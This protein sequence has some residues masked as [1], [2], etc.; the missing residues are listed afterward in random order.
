MS[1][2]PG[3]GTP[4]ATDDP[5]SGSAAKRKPQHNSK[6]HTAFIKS[7]PISFLHVE[8]V[9]FLLEAMPII[10]RM[11]KTVNAQ[12]QYRDGKIQW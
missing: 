12:L 4:G 8:S 9:A 11:H 3:E 1:A 6:R 2:L 10:V 7:P 5:A